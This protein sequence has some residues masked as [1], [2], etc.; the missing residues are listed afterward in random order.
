ME[1]TDRKGEGDSLPRISHSK[2]HASTSHRS[3]THANTDKDSLPAI[4][5]QAS[6]KVNASEQRHD[7]DK[8]ASED[9]HTNT[10]ENSQHDD[11]PVAIL[12]STSAARSK[13]SSGRNS[14][15]G[16]HTDGEETSYSSYQ[17]EMSMGES[18]DI[19]DDGEEEEGTDMFPKF[20]KKV[21]KYLEVQSS[22]PILETR[23]STETTYLLTDTC[24]EYTCIH[25]CLCL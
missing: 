22:C 21:S 14:R 8:E 12:S 2:G 4:K 16:T 24:D 20:I 13:P 1:T 9:P 23:H 19:L 3:K 25:T 17:R 18:T 5:R 15:R 7:K 11:D 6:S 10:S